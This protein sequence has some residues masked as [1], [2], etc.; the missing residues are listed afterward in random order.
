MTKAM[1]WYLANAKAKAATTSTKSSSVVVLLC[2]GVV[3]CA[4]TLCTTESAADCKA[5]RTHTVT[6]TDEKEPKVQSETLMAAANL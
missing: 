1:L 3:K 5:A 4:R 6:G 2:D